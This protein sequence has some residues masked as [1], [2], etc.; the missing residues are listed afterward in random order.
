MH[1]RS[2]QLNKDSGRLFLPESTFFNAGY[3]FNMLIEYAV[4]VC[5]NFC[6]WADENWLFVACEG[7]AHQSSWFNCCNRCSASCYSISWGLSLLI[8]RTDGRVM[9]T[10]QTTDLGLVGAGL[11]ELKSS[12]ERRRPL[13]ICCLIADY[14]CVPTTEFPLPAPCAVYGSSGDGIRDVDTDAGRGR[15]VG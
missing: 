1:I 2:I 8:T 10:M 12:S 7:S 11:V 13:T 4:K 15:F 3:S 9:E 5:Y 14:Q 6:L